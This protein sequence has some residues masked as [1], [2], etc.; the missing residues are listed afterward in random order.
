MNFCLNMYFEVFLSKNI[1]N[2]NF[3]DNQ[4]QSLDRSLTSIF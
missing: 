3:A 2:N 1:F 4:I